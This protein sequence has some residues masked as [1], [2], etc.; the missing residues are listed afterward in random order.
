MFSYGDNHAVLP[1]R[2]PRGAVVLAEIAI[3]RVMDLKQIPLTICQGFCGV[4]KD[5]NS[6]E[7]SFASSFK[8]WETRP[9]EVIRETSTEN[10]FRPES[11]AS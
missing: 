11:A 6:S 9:C 7:I 4:M 1:E 10:I 2:I 8:I 3:G 5:K